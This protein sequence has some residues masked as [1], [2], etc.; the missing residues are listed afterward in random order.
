MRFIWKALIALA[1]IVAA[2]AITAYLVLQPPAP[3]ALPEAGAVLDGVTLIEPGESRRPG[4]RVEVEGDRIAAVTAAAGDAGAPFAGMF[5]LPGLTDMHVHFPPPSLPGQTELFAFLH[6]YHG[7]TTARDAGDTD[8]QS[9][10]PARRGVAEGRFPGPRLFACGPFVDGEPPLW[11][12]S[13]VARNPEEG[14][15]AVR[16]VDEAGFDCIKAYNELDAPTLEA[17]RAEAKER[18]LPVIGHV[19]SRVPFEVARLDDAQHLIGVPPKLADESIRF[20]QVMRAWLDLDDERLETMVA[21][22]RDLGIAHTPTMVTIDRLLAQRDRD[23]ALREPDAQLLPRFYREVVWSPEIGFTPARGL[24]AA[25]FDMLR[26]AQAVQLRTI[27]SLFEAGVELHTGTDTL[28]AFVVPGAALH[29]ELRL[30]VAAG[31]TPEQALTLS[32]RVSP[33][34]LGVEGLGDLRPGAPAEMVVFRDDPTRDLA[35]LGSIAA[36]VRGGR[37]ITRAQLDAQ[38]ARYRAHHEGALYDAL[39]TPLVRR[40]VAAAVPGHSH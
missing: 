33:R 35:A 36:V 39:V 17:I 14:R 32:T 13:I 16:A 34:F 22:S 27:R 8:G 4:M 40:A 25:D 37:L 5:V 30:F 26:E 24:E 15:A 28:I 11:K 7:V 31:L 23:A 18:G 21:A 19:P 29:R 12:N 9:S 2:A 6:L 20:P 1:A 3:L 10:E 38:L